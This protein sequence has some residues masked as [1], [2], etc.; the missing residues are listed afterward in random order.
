MAEYIG[1]TPTV[2][3]G[4]GE[5]GSGMFLDLAYN[6][7]DWVPASEIPQTS[8][9]MLLPGAFSGLGDRVI[10]NAYAGLMELNHYSRS[11]TRFEAQYSTSGSDRI[12]PNSG[13]DVPFR[14]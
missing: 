5:T 13:R 14:H 9:Y 11:D 12:T 4:L 6:V 2:I 8:A 7:R 1:M 10:A 3:I